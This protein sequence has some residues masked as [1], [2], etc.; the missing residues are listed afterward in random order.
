ML[1]K[2]ADKNLKHSTIITIC[3]ITLSIAV[4]VFRSLSCSRDNILQKANEYFENTQYFM[5]AKYFDKIIDSGVLEVDVYKNYGTALL[6]LGNYDKSL[7]YFKLALNLD[8]YDYDNYYCIGNVLY[9]KANKF[10][11]K[12]IFL[13]AVE[14]LEKGI[15]LSLDFEELYLLIGL[16][17]RGCGFYENARSCYNRALLCEKFNKA[18]F[19]NLIGNTYREENKYKEALSYYKKAKECDPLFASAYCSAGDMCLKLKNDNE[20]LLNYKKA[21]EVNEGFIT[22]Y[23][24]LANF[25]YDRNNFYEAKKWLLKALKINKDNDM[26]NYILGM[27]YK[28]LGMQENSL[29]YLKHAAFCGN[30]DAACWLIDNKIDLR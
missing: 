17:Y 13:Q 20:A 4:Y 27:V 14:Y 21:I 8:P 25:Y 19:Y 23:V 29:E 7:K 22:P 1:R 28:N 18:G 6:K 12:A 15:N 10:K 11:E 24:S 2:T 3:F 16:C 30:D 9:H 5:A 26:A